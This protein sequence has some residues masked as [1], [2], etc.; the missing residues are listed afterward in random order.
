MEHG[1]LK[2]NR[3]AVRETRFCFLFHL[4][5]VTHKNSLFIQ[6]IY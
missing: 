5:D 4:D 6:I 3:Q 1:V 2:C